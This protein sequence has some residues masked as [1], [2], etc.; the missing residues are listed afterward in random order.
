MKDGPDTTRALFAELKIKASC[1]N[2]PVAF[3]RDEAAFQA[4]LKK[5]DD[6]AKF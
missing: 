2:L 6:A 3:A 4:D 1:V 5:L